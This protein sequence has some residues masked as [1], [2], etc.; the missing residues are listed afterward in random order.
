MFSRVCIA[1]SLW[2][3]LTS[4]QTGQ[5]CPLLGPIYPPPAHPSTSKEFGLAQQNTQTVLNDALLTGSTKFGPLDN[6]T[7]SFSIQGFSLENDSPIFDYNFAAPGLNGSL[8][9]GTLDSS[10]TYRI[11]SMSKLLT[12]YTLLR[13]SGFSD[14]SQSITKFVPEL[15]KQSCSKEDDLDKVCWGDV[16]VG[17]L[18]SHM[19]GILREYALS[20]LAVA[21]GSLTQYGFPV[22]NPSAVPSCGYP[23]PKPCSRQEFFNGLA[24][25]HPV[26][27]PFTTP[28]YSNVAFQLLGYAIESVTGRSFNDVLTTEVLKP[29]G[30]SSTSL[31]LPR[32]YTNAIIPFNATVSGW[33]ADAADEG[34]AGGMYSTTS[35]FSKIGRSILNFTLLGASMTRAWMK[36]LTHTSS[37]TFSVGAPWEIIR[38]SLPLQRNSTSTR[39]VDLYTKSGN[40]GLYSAIVVLSPDHNFGFTILSTGVN[41]E[42]QVLILSNLLTD[43]WLP[44]F[45]A[46]AMEEA[47]ARFVGTYA[48]PASQNDTFITVSFDRNVP[49]LGISEWK[50]RGVDIKAAYLLLQ[51]APSNSTL[52][53]SLYPTGLGDSL[54]VGFRAT[55]DVLPETDTIGAFSTKCTDWAAV[56][57]A[58]YGK[59]GIDEFV[60]GLDKCDGKAASLSPRVLRQ[61][62]VRV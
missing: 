10:T 34:P 43:I 3:L 7:I 42:Q 29:L 33:D 32:N 60:F 36:P 18:A 4:A 50:S 6:T 24:A 61:K 30:A 44:A 5:V 51:N 9:S 54:D 28:V 53:I 35:D 39:I 22:L 38:V 52:S 56:D 11:G 57:G 48:D 27:P 46:A 47:N 8:T 59:V 20:D 14:F 40:I 41:S 21:D 58:A 19:A 17:A 1:A 13:S 26:F 23:N 2:S 45:E 15:A 49:G 37:L 62:L 31:A 55:L 25:F 16:T 12:V